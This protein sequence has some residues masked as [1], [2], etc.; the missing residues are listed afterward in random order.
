LF[1]FYAKYPLSVAG[2]RSFEKSYPLSRS[3]EI[4]FFFV[5]PRRSF[6]YYYYPACLE[7]PFISSCVLAA[8]ITPTTDNEIPCPSVINTWWCFVTS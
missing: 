6:N 5:R 2:P 4:L 1:L 3:I 8:V 7:L